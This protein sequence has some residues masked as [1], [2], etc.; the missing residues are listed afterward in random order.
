MK[1]GL[2]LIFVGL[3]GILWASSGVAVQDFFSHSEK[4]PME[5]TNIR[6]C[7][8]GLILI[9]MAAR[10]K[11]FRLSVKKLN[12]SPKL[13]FDVTIYRRI[14]IEK[15]LSVNICRLSGDF[16]GEFGRSGLDFD[17]N[18]GSEEKFLVIGKK[19]E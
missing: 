18:G 9:I 15:G 3:A 6:M 14:S 16:M 1:M 7:I 8:A 11:S 17:N 5:L 19:I 10:R 2:A 4:S 13:W 12:D